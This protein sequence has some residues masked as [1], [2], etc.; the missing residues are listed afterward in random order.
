MSN[1]PRAA[2]LKEFFWAHI[3]KD[4]RLLAESLKLTQDEVVLLLHRV[5]FDILQY[6]PPS[7]G[8]RNKAYGAWP[9]KAER[10]EWESAFYDCFFKR[11]FAKAADVVTLANYKLKESAKNSEKTKSKFYM[12]VWELMEA[13]PVKTQCLYEHENFWKFR[14]M[15]TFDTLRNALQ[16]TDPTQHLTLKSFAEMV[17]PPS[18]HARDRLTPVTRLTPV[19]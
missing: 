18:T 8:D 13:D 3:K 5:C 2:K 4:L 14:P 17:S 16:Q 9:T 1:A 19:G 11:V 12:V 10:Q 7:T 6:E 15:I